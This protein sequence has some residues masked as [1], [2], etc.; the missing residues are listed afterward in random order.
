MNN[1]VKSTLGV[2]LAAFLVLIATY[3][4][5]LVEAI[6]ALWL[7]LIEASKTAPLGL[8]SFGVAF[9]LAV[10]SRWFLRKWIPH[11][12]C[13]LSRDFIIDGAALLIGVSV[14]WLQ[15][16]ANAPID[17]LNALWIGLAAGLSAPLAYN[18][19][20]ALVGLIGRAM[21]NAMDAGDMN[22]KGDMP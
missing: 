11:L 5:Q 3:G 6:K 8:S 10:L 2:S 22:E 4:A 15:M 16:A 13:P 20:A 9:G 21:K 17:R 7:L 19:F 1:W 18:F 14:T 12:K